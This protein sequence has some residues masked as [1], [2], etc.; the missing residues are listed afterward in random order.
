MHACK[1]CHPQGHHAH[2][3]DGADAHACAHA[4]GYEE[5]Q[6]EVVVAARREETL[7]DTRLASLADA[8]AVAFPDTRVRTA[9]P[10]RLPRELSWG[11][12]MAAARAFKVLPLS[13]LAGIALL[14]CACSP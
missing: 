11:L 12:R 1:A 9:C 4:Q 7:R 10:A 5:E 6:I 13:L 3:P 2:A 14:L 8:R